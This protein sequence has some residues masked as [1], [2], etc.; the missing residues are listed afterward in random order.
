MPG[1]PD[2]SAYAIPAGTSIVV[3]TKPASTSFGSHAVEWWSSI[4]AP[5]SQRCQPDGGVATG[6]A[7]RPGSGCVAL[8]FRSLR[9]FTVLPR[10]WQ[11]PR[12]VRE[13]FFGPAVE[14]ADTSLTRIVPNHSAF[15]KRNQI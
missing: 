14:D 8:P 7:R 5:G 6:R 4:R 11:L 15:R 1:T 12:F 13:R 9:W 10:V 2:A 3:N